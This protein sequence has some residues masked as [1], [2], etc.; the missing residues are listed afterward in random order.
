MSALSSALTIDI[1]HA[2]R[3]VVDWHWNFTRPHRDPFNRLYHIRRGEGDATIA[4]RPLRL[5]AK[6]L[7]LLRAD[8]PIQLHHPDVEV[9]H[10]WMHFSAEFHP[11]ASLFDYFDVPSWVPAASVADVSDKFD[12]LVSLRDQDDPASELESQG[13]ARLL[14]APFMAGGERPDADRKL[15]TSNRFQKVIDHIERHLSR[16]MEVA[17]LARLIGLHPTYFSNLFSECFGTGPKRYL[18]QRRIERAQMLL[19][20]SDV[21][22]KEVATEVGFDNPL[23]FSRLFRKYTG[24]PPGAYRRHHQAILND[25]KKSNRR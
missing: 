3:T 6:R 4:G 14:L 23:Y 12:R 25:G 18:C 19:I 17:E 22:L 20:H 2:N 10:D 11:G 13:L 5:R 9:D 15:R 16:P 21:K 8:V 24:V 7:Y 1:H